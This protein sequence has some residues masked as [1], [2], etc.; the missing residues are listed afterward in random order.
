MWKISSHFG[1]LD[2]FLDMRYK[3]VMTIEKEYCG[4]EIEYHMRKRFWLDLVH[5]SNL[6]FSWLLYFENRECVILEIWSW[7]I[8]WEQT[9][10]WKKNWAIPLWVD[11]P[12]LSPIKPWNPFSLI[13]VLQAKTLYSHIP[14]W[15]QTSWKCLGKVK[16]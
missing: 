12:I 1:Y 16:D 11:W 4:H 5:R 10:L 3:R 14:L 13:T 6:E 9:T 8:N 2:S 15:N 7:A